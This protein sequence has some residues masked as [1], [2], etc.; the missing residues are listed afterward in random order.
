MPRVVVIGSANVDLTVRLP[1][2]PKAGETVSGGEF[3]KCFGGKGANQAVA[4]MRAGAEV[5]FLA[6]LG[7]DLMGNELRAHLEGLGLPGQYL[8]TQQSAPTGTALILVDLQGRN[9]IGVAPGANSSLSQQE[10]ISSAEL[11]QWGELLLC[12]LEV[13]LEAVETALELAKKSGMVT[14]L[15]PAPVKQLPKETLRLVDVITPNEGEAMA[16]TGWASPEAAARRL[17]EMGPSKVILTLGERG[18]MFLRHGEPCFLPSYKVKAVDT[19]GCGDAFN[20]ALACALAEGKG[21][22][23]ALG[24]AVAAGALAATVKGAQ[25]AM[26]SREGILGLMR[27]QGALYEA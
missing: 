21:L 14:M 5:K 18:V 19:T 24:F 12:Q 26:P 4:A 10:V 8:I 13:P 17:W 16:L 20:G 1:R 9:L 23:E 22:E 11:F 2:L 7:Q 15:N 25:D 3:Y 6:K 27:A